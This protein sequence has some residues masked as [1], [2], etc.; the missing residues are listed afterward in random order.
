MIPAV[1]AAAVLALAGGS[2][3]VSKPLTDEELAAVKEQLA[4]VAS[5]AVA[6]SAAAAPPAAVPAA[7]APAAAPAAE[8]APAAAAVPAP[9][10]SAAA[11]AAPA[12]AAPAPAAETAQAPAAA[13]AAGDALD[14]ATRSGCMACHKV[15]IKLVGPAY[16][17]VA[18]RYRGDVAALE[19]L[20]AKVKSGGMGVWGEIPM[21][22]NAHVSDEDI[23]TI[24][25]WVLSQ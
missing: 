4:P 5:V 13:S 12:E 20:V 15:D 25:T 9:E 2:D 8:T 14:L 1:L 21:P 6:G 3:E 10:M 7:A 19:T 18:A 22:P 11:T 17:E 24:V 23:R 16:Q